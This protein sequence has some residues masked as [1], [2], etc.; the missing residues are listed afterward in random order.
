MRPW[1][2]LASVPKAFLCPFQE[3]GADECRLQSRTAG[4]GKFESSEIANGRWEKSFTTTQSGYHDHV[5][6]RAATP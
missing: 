5:G 1:N 4:V 2:H 3:Q 6:R